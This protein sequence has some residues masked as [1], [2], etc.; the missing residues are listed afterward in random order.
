MDLASLQID[1][2][3]QLK[4]KILKWNFN[5]AMIHFQVPKDQAKDTELVYV[6]EQL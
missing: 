1:Q 4:P 5:T 3:F 6:S 2:C